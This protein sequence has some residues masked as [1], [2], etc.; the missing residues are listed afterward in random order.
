MHENQDVNSF[1]HH[2]DGKVGELRVD[3]HLSI[4]VMDWWVFEEYDLTSILHRNGGKVGALRIN[5]RLP[6]VVMCGE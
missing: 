5:P 2:N 3:L 4:V 1:L 6:M